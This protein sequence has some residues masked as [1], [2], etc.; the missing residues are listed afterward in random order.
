MKISLSK[1]RDDQSVVLR[2]IRGDGS[3]S[4]QKVDG[5]Q[6]AFFPL[7]DLTHFAVESTVGAGEGFFALIAEGWEIAD[8]TGKGS[9]GP[10]PPMALWVERVVGLLDVERAT[11]QRMT[12]AE[13]LDTIRQADDRLSGVPLRL[14]EERLTEIRRLRSELFARWHALPPGESLELV[15]ERAD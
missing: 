14:T 11:G 5:K 13:M 1:H 2:C 12:A 9:R 15:F 7:H 8:T 6:A 10:L 3:V 4:W